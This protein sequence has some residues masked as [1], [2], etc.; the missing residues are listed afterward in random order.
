MLR[1]QNPGDPIQLSGFLRTATFD[2]NKTRITLYFRR[3]KRDQPIHAVVLKD[4]S[5]DPPSIDSLRQ[6]FGKKIT[7]KG[8]ALADAH[9]KVEEVRIDRFEDISLLEEPPPAE[10]PPEESPPGDQSPEEQPAPKAETPS[11]TF[12]PDDR[13]AIDQLKNREEAI[14]TGLFR[15]TSFSGTKNSL[16]LEFASQ[17]EKPVRGVIQE[18]T[19][20]GEFSQEA[21]EELI[22]KTITLKGNIIRYSHNNRA[23]VRVH[24]REDIIVSP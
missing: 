20:D 18:K 12:S 23:I 8:E 21:F 24:S 17:E 1:E 10:P 19:Y 5:E 22:G 16:Y 15:S 4:Q 6:F 3:A 13:D 2:K 7:L 11:S 14:L 9:K